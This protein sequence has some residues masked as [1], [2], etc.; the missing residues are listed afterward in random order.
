MVIFLHPPSCKSTHWCGFDILPWTR[1]ST[2]L[3]GFGICNCFIMV[4]FMELLPSHLLP[5]LSS[6]SIYH[7]HHCLDRWSAS[8][9]W[10]GF[11]GSTTFWH[12]AISSAST[13]DHFTQFFHSTERIHCPS[14]KFRPTTAS[15][16]NS[17]NSSISSSCVELE[18]LKSRAPW[19]PS[20]GVK[21]FLSWL[22]SIEPASSA[23]SSSASQ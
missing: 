4:C 8:T 1:N 3:R 6:H 9:R 20:L 7:P 13:H 16:L 14:T 10:A 19:M 2:W 21:I 12:P 11:H 23:S 17:S 18:V 22:R 5:P 15:T